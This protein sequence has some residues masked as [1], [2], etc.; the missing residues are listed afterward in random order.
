M[1]TLLMIAVF[2]IASKLLIALSKV[3]VKLA[4]FAIIVLGALII[5]GGIVCA[6]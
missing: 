5:L 1:L 4:L 6:L 2:I 3:W